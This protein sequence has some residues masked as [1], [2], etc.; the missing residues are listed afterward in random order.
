MIKLSQESALQDDVRKMIIELNDYLNPLSPPEFQFQMTAEQ[1]D[2]K[3]TTVFVAR[4]DSGKAV[5][6]GALKVHNCGI[7]EVK[8]MFTSPSVR[9]K[10]VGHA[11]LNKVE[12]LARDKNLIILKLETGATKGFEPAWRI[13][14][15]AGY[16]QCDAFLDYP[17]SD[18]SRF[19][20]K[21]IK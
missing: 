14:E 16:N 1:M 19:Y 13:Y 6:M 11:L 5:G 3:D 17:V 10:G 4:D 9:G 15:R 12:E 2:E 20:E 7:G 8:R 18:Y 21:K